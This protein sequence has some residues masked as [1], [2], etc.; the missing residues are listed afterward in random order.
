MDNTAR[1]VAAVAANN[2][3]I[4]N[5]SRV[6]S[7]LA[8]GAT[9]VLGLTKRQV[10]DS[11]VELIC[12]GHL[13][14]IAHTRCYSHPYP[15]DNDWLAD[16]EDRLCGMHVLR[17]GDVEVTWD[18]C[19][20]AEVLSFDEACAEFGFTPEQYTQILIADGSL[21]EHPDG[22]YIPGPHPSVFDA[23]CD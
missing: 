13:S 20:Q 2:L 19:R 7:A 15:T 8:E 14:S 11:I 21:I 9:E 22:G 10:Y 23:G 3:L 4:E 18:Y 17:F 16:A 12:A 6:A 1:T 5:D